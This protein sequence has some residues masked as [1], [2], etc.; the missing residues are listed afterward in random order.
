MRK[1]DADSRRLTGRRAG[2]EVPASLDT[3]EGAFVK[4]LA[5]YLVYITRGREREKT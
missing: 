4:V 5:T 2:G 1:W 3:V